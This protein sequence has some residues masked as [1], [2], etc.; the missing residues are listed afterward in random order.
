LNC[1]FLLCFPHVFFLISSIKQVVPEPQAFSSFRE[2]LYY[3]QVTLLFLRMIICFS[4]QFSDCFMGAIVWLQRTE[5]ERVCFGRSGI[6]GWGLFARRNIQEGEMVWMSRSSIITMQIRTK[7]N[8]HL[9]YV[10]WALHVHP[11]SVAIVSTILILS[12]F[13]NIV[14]NKWDAALQIWGRHAID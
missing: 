6:H 5:N 14:A 12:R 2:R 8:Y 13:L 3:L 11:L 9:L 4:G 1:L 10:F 7:F